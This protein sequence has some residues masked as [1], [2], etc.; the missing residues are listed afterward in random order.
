MEGPRG[1][2]SFD[3]LRG[4]IVYIYIYIYVDLYYTYI[5]IYTHTHTLTLLFLPEMLE[6][7]CMVFRLLTQNRVLRVF[8][9]QAAS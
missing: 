9:T 7:T 5:Y 2:P 8:C 3:N 6:S 1:P 4:H